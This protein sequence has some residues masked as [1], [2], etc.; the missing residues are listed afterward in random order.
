[1]AVFAMLILLIASNYF[2]YHVILP[3][4]SLGGAG[5]FLDFL[6]GNIFS[7]SD[8]FIYKTL[9]WLED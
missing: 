6:G 1:M 8:S 5:L 3:I 2:N 9:D 4:I 7:R